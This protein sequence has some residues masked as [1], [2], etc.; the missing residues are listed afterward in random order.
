ML[1]PLKRICQFEVPGGGVC[2]DEGCEDMHLSRLAGPDG[3]SSAQPTD[4][5][6]A[7]YLVDVLP[8][9]WLGE[10]STILRTKIALA[11]EQIRV[12]N[13]QMNLEERVAHALASLGT[14]P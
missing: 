3:R 8:P 10:N 11:L 4:E 7:E 5:D 14:P 9:D 2:R 12:K 6:T 13:P 1:D